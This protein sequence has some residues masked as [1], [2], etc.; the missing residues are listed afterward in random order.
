M[1]GWQAGGAHGQAGAG[2]SWPRRRFAVAVHHH[3]QGRKKG[4][5]EGRENHHIT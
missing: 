1:V 3:R 4:R 2:G 5:K